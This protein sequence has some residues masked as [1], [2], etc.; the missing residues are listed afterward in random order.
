MTTIM[1]ARRVWS[2]RRGMGLL[3]GA[4]MLV[5][6]ALLYMILSN[7]S[8]RPEVVRYGSVVIAPD[9]PVLCPGETLTYPVSVTVLESDLPV[10]LHVVEAW[11]RESDGLTLQSTA[12]SYELP[13]LRPVDVQA[14]ARRV[15]PDLA[16]GVY[17]LDHVSVNGTT[18]A[19]TVGPVEIRPCP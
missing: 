5:T 7:V 14:T 13:I 9:Q 6:M 10:L 12:R 3:I 2:T 15:T 17:W 1:L 18:E 16:P 8:Q 19:Y 4:M 11:H